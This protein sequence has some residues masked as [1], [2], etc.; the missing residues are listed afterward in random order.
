[1]AAEAAVKVVP[2]ILANPQPRDIVRIASVPKTVHRESI[3][4]KSRMIQ[5]AHVERVFKDSHAAVEIDKGAIVRRIPAD[6]CTSIPE[7]DRLPDV[8]ISRVP[9]LN[10]LGGGGVGGGG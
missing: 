3:E 10:G 7:L 2:L 4:K 8:V 5:R 9:P 1:M 6:V